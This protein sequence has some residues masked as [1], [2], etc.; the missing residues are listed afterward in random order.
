MPPKASSEV[1][2]FDW[3]GVR[4]GGMDRVV[5]ISVERVSGDVEGIHLL[6]RDNNSFWI[7]LAVEFAFHR[8]AGLRGG[9]RDQVDD[10]TVADQGRG[11]PIHRDE[12]EQ[13]VLYLVPLAG[14]RRQVM[15]HDIDA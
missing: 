11:L 7:M 4:F 9:R 6:A 10:D 14:A 3:F 13:A 15:H 8:Q 12:G 2:C 1:N 5:P